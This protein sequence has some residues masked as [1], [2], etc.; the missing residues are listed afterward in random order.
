MGCS[1]TCALGG[2][3][4]QAGTYGG[5]SRVQADNIGCELCSVHSVCQ[6]QMLCEAGA[7]ELDGRPVVGLTQ[8]AHD[9]LIAPDNF[10][11]S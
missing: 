7:A 6:R 2:V 1:N 8:S 9:D 3:V 11:T 10:L 5:S 4:L